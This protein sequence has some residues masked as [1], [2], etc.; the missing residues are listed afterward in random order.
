MKIVVEISIT[1]CFAIFAYGM[2]FPSFFDLLYL[3]IMSMY[4]MILFLKSGLNC[5]VISVSA[6]SVELYTGIP[7][8]TPSIV[9]ADL[10]ISNFVSGRLEVL[11]LFVNAG[12]NARFVSA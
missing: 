8:D 12:M 2:V 10:L 9:C 7:K 1:L 4:F 5:A 3:K 11:K 6:E